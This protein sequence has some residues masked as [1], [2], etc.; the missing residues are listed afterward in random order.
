MKKIFALM[1]AL[2]AMT[3]PVFAEPAA[4]APAAAGAA[5]GGSFLIII[6]VFVALYGWMF[7]SERKRKKNAQNML[8]SME[9][10]DEVITIGGVI[11]RV[12]ALKDET[13]V[14]ET[15]SERVRIRFLRTAIQSVEKLKMDD[16]KK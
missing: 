10:G 12:V 16:A 9:A 6:V 11:G 3:A 8:N 5:G 2:F 13:V 1:T 4:A 7:W 14:I 15:G